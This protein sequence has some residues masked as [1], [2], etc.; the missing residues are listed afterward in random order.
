MEHLYQ[1]LENVVAAIQSP[2]IPRKLV[3]GVSQ[4]NWQVSK[5]C[6]R[7]STWD[8]IFIGHHHI[9]RFKVS[10]SIFSEQELLLN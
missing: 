7:W 6:E 9:F 5:V 4:K 10:S 1:G 8:S 2:F 3:K